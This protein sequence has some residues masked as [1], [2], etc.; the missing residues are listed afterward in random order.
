MA[1]V[2]EATR[3]EILRA[4]QKDATYLEQVESKVRCFDLNATLHANLA[5]KEHKDIIIIIIDIILIIIII[6]KVSSLVVRLWGPT[7]WAQWQRWLGPATSCLYYSLTTLRC[8]QTLGEE[9]TEVVQVI[10]DM[11]NNN[12]CMKEF[13]VSRKHLTLPSSLSRLA[14]VVVH[15]LGPEILA[16]ALRRLEKKLGDPKL[17]VSPAARQTLLKILP[18][19]QALASGLQ[20]LHTCL[21]YL[22]VI[23]NFLF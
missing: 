10:T 12:K 5:R 19:L 21:F 7:L 16:F 23:Q 2:R 8:C 13:Q 9:Y 17:E 14:L 3:G 22:Q 20:K 11:N 4:A 18:L 1:R 15:S 6:V